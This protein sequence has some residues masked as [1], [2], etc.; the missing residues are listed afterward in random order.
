M[1][2]GIDVD[3][4]LRDFCQGFI[5][6]MMREYPEHFKIDDNG[7]PITELVHWNLEHN[8]NCSRKVLEQVYRVDYPEEILGNG[9]P[10]DNGKGVL[11]LRELMN[12]YPNYN[13]ICI[14]SQKPDIRW[15]TLKWLADMQLNFE[16]VHFIKGI[17]KWKIDIDYLVDD[18]PPNWSSWKKNRK[19]DNFILMDRPYNQHIKPYY[20][21]RELK[22]IEDIMQ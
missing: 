16:A 22:E 4:V 6:V 20:R 21:I 3:G 1:K 15:Y 9:E 10:I 19:D 17:N 14:T 11:Q 7:N 12:K 2:I 13:W 5:N 8:F 18:S